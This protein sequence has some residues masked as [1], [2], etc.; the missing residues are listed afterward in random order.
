MQLEIEPSIIM[1]FHNS[2]MIANGMTANTA[3][4]LKNWRQSAFKPTIDIAHDNLG[5]G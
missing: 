2:L 5:G 3:I 1:V 4:M